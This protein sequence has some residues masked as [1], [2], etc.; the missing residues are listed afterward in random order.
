M[1]TRHDS[2]HL[3]GSPFVR[4]QVKATACIWTDSS[5]Q[6][7]YEV[8][9]IIIYGSNEDTGMGNVPQ[10]AQSTRTWTSSEPGSGSRIATPWDEDP[11][12][13]E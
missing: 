7:P 4:A 13:L 3:L 12:A 8:G 5:S 1:G 9:I 6:Q 11:V 10:G 2:Q